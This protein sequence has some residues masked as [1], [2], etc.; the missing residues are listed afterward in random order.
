MADDGPYG[1]GATVWGADRGA[2]ERIAAGLRVGSVDVI[3]EP[4]RAA[5]M[6]L[7][8][9]FEP[10]KQSGFG[11]EGGLA[12]L[13]AFTA[14]QAIT[15]AGR[16]VPRAACH[17]ARADRHRHRRDDQRHLEPG[18][19]RPLY[20][21]ASP[22]ASQASPALAAENGAYALGLL[23]FYLILPPPRAAPDARRGPGSR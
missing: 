1:L 8:T 19:A 13:A 3:T 5:G 22:T 6:A 23:L 4:H 10:R 11:V 9:P 16:H 21:R 7:G 14:P 20:R 2:A 15:Y 18:D 17:A 12:G